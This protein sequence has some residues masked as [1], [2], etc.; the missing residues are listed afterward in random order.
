MIDPLAITVM[1]VLSYFDQN[2]LDAG[3]TYQVDTYHT[4]ASV[5]H[6]LM[7]GLA[8]AAVTTSQGMMQIPEDLRRKIVVFRHIADIP[9]FVFMARPGMSAADVEKLRGL[10]LGF[11]REEEGLEFFSRTGYNTMKLASEASMKR[12]DIYLKQTRKALKP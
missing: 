10:L 3:V 1:A 9:A 4:H 5:A 2:D 8:S 11:G 12:A 6:A 7:S